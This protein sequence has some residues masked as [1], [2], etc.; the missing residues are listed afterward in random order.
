MRYKVGNKQIEINEEDFIGEGNESIV[1]KYYD[2]VL[3]IYKKFVRKDRLTE[4]EVNYLRYLVTKRI[5]LPKDS[6]YDEDDIFSG[7]SLLY[8]ESYSKD[9]IKKMKVRDLKKELELIREDIEL[10]SSRNIS[11]EDFTYDN[12]IYN[13]SLYITD[14]GSFKLLGGFNTKIYKENIRIFN[15]FFV[16]DVLSRILKLTKKEQSNLELLVDSSGYVGDILSD[17]DKTVSSY[18]RNVARK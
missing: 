16:K 8:E 2:I 14:P 9:N 3:K 1:Y 12:L 18:I 11:L 17:E 6:I 10:L 7:Y 5:L 4:E 15:Y 13:G